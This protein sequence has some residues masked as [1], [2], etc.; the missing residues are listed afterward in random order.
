[1]VP[2]SRDP[3]GGTNGSHQGL[4]TRKMAAGAHGIAVVNSSLEP[5][6]RSRVWL[7]YGESAD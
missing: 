5:D 7:L 2:G 3:N 4:L 1:M 6:A